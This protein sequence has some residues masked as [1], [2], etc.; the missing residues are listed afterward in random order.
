MSPAPDQARTT[1]AHFFATVPE[2]EFAMLTGS[3]AL[4]TAAAT[5]D[6]NI[7]LQWRPHE[8]WL[9]L[10]D[11]Q[12]VLHRRIA[13][14]LGIGRED[15]DLSGLSRVN[16]SMRANFAEEG[17]VLKGEDSLA[18]RHYSPPD[19]HNRVRKWQPPP[20]WPRPENNRRIDT[21]NPMIDQNH[22]A[23]GNEP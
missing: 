23:A 2:L 22:S 1:L 19:S 16:L 13:D 6:W 14:I 21:L 10:V 17:I 15:I 11:T 3:R 5:S 12:E 7:A 9:A 4:G 20:T 18:Y 8:D